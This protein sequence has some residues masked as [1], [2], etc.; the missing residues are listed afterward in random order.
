M[1]SQSGIHRILLFLV[2][3]KGMMLVIK[4]PVWAYN[5]S[6]YLSFFAFFF[7][8]HFSGLVKRCNFYYH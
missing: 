1:K 6:H 2:M 4:R 5:Q 3:T 7:F 8:F